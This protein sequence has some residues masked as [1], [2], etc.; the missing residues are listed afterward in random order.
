MT[1]DKS[2]G[3]WTAITVVAACAAL[4][5]SDPA[6]AAPSATEK[7]QQAKLKAQGKYRLCMSN[8]EAGILV[9]KPDQKLTCRDK[10]AA[11]R[12]KAD[13]K[14][15]AAGTSC[16]FVDNGD[17]TISDLDTGLMWEMKTEDFGLRDYRNTFSW[18]STGTEPDG[19]LF[20]QFVPALNDCVSPNGEAMT[21]GFAG[22]CDWRVPTVAELTSILTTGCTTGPCIDPVFG[23]TANTM[24]YTATRLA[25]A[26]GWHWNVSF[27]PPGFPAAFTTLAGSFNPVRAV[28]G[29][30]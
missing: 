8:N 28:R 19:T 17:F 30:L 9:G 29:G 26:P 2:A 10:F 13:A 12:A 18:S 7:C 5:A 3:R 4:L 24:T 25:A 6:K 21:S 22:Y 11:A 20:T 16:R 1:G 23:P 27:F 15:L 14:A